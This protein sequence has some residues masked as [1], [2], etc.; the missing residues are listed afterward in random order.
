[1]HGEKHIP[2]YLAVAI[3]AMITT[4]CVAQKT[5]PHMAPPRP[6]PM[7]QQH[8]SRPPAASSQQ[9]AQVTR[10][11]GHAGDWLRRYKDLPPEEQEKALQ[12]DPTFQKLPP[13]RQQILRQRL[14]HFSSLPPQQ[15]LQ[16]LN[17]METWEHLTPEQKQ[18]ARQIFRQMQQLPPDRQRMV[19]T[20]VRDLRAMPPDQRERVIDSD[21]FKGMFS[22]QERE[23][24][25]GVTRLPLTPAEP[26]EEVGPQE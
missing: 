23:M 7:P 4:L 9:Q 24:M 2:G 26:G 11:K 15:Q 6:A 22:D 12:S 25:R 20:A 13:A 16:M 5:A 8:V 17:R 18:Q 21:R 19:R 1:M 10:Q 14:Q 3:L